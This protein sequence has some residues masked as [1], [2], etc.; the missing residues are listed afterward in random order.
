MKGKWSRRALYVQREIQGNLDVVNVVRSARV[1]SFV[2]VLVC[3]PRGRA[4]ATA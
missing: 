1:G 4:N 2:G 3:W